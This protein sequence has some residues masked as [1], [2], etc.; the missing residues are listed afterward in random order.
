M[1]KSH[2]YL[3]FKCEQENRYERLT[4]PSNIVSYD[5][6]IKYLETKKKICKS[7]ALASFMVEFSDG[8]KTDK[9]MLLD[10]NRNVGKTMSFI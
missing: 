4:F 6:I 2:I 5:E 3:K 10:L 8:K 9:I 7:L 1:M